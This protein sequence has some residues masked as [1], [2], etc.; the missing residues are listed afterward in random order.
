MGRNEATIKGISDMKYNYAHQ[1]NTFDR[2][3]SKVFESSRLTQLTLK[4]APNLGIILKSS[5]HH[6]LLKIQKPTQSRKMV[7]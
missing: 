5:L 1:Q 3:K 6:L 4:V 2:M 7:C